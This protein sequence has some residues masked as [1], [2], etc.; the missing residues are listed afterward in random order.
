MG[1]LGTLFGGGVDAIAKTVGGIADNLHTSG[2]EKAKARLDERKLDF[3]FAELE[4][5]GASRQVAVNLQEAR[6]KSVFVAG[7]RPF[8]GWISAVGFGLHVI[9]IPIAELGVALW[10]P[11][12]AIKMPEFDTVLIL[13]ILG[14]MLGIGKGL[15]SIEKVKG[16]AQDRIRV[17]KKS[18]RNEE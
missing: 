2:E 8:V 10:G 13:T 9:V 1:I 15:R 16:V 11:E 3:K 5:A 14:G 7:W 17:S 4:D 18:L 6:H 12:P